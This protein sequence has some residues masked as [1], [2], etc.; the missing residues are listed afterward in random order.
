MNNSRGLQGRAADK[1]L[2]GCCRVDFL[3]LLLR[4]HQGSLAKADAW[5]SETPTCSPA[6]FFPTSRKRSTLGLGAEVQASRRMLDPLKVPGCVPR[7][8]EGIISRQVDKQ[9]IGFEVIFN[10]TD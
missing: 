8:R 1:R 6:V 3:L 10:C 5:G 7:L 2:Q 9:V 4:P